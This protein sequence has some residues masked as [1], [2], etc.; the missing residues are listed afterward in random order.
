MKAMHNYVYK[1]KP[2][3]AQ[4]ISEEKKKKKEKNRCSYFCCTHSV[5]ETDEHVNYM[6]TGG[7]ITSIIIIVK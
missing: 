7:N 4:T 2:K 5:F 3:K 6:N 1:T